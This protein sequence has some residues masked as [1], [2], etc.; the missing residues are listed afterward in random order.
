MCQPY[1]PLRY[2]TMQLV[3]PSWII[4]LALL[5]DKSSCIAGTDVASTGSDASLSSPRN[6]PISPRIVNGDISNPELN[7]FFVRAGFDEFYWTPETLCGASLIHS[8]IFV[9][10][11]HCSG[12]FNYGAL[13]FD[14]TTNDFTRMVPVDRQ[15]RHPQWNFDNS[16]LNFDIMVWMLVVI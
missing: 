3:A 14:P 16:M 7:T 12:A 6:P 11:A 2:L 15:L 9:T 4:V 13:I 8:D 5:C 1:Q 10:A